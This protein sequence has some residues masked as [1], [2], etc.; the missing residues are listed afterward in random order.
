MNVEEIVIYQYYTRPEWGNAIQVGTEDSKLILRFEDGRERKVREGALSEFQVMDFPP[1]QA[2]AI[3][4]K[5]RGLEGVG[6]S[7]SSKRPATSRSRMKL[8]RVLPTFEE[9]LRLFE[10][11]YP[12]GF[13]GDTYIN[14]E[15]GV[16]GAKGSKGYKAAAIARAGKDLAESEFNLRSTEEMFA[17][18]KSLMGA[19]NIVHP[20]EGSI[21]FGSTPPG[22]RAPFVAALRDL[23][24]GTDEFGPRFDRFVD[25]IQLKDGEGEP[26]RTTW[27]VATIFSALYFPDQH[28]A[29]KPTFFQNQAEIL[30][31][32]LRY[33]PE[34]NGTTYEE[35]RLI[36][37]ATRSA[38]LEHQHDPRDLMDAYTFIWVTLS[39]NAKKPAS[40]ES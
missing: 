32:P 36:A 19:T 6:T 1:V 29:V 9:Q 2:R 35:F 5:I 24:H 16:A 13:Q 39:D 33:V 27:P 7:K 22:A 10:Q 21:P 8:A 26:R 30:G 34:P 25:S 15:R 31:L 4:A 37:E 18:A 28:V 40:I 38:L 3:V 14:N 20:Q 17:V 11:R 23:L 12:G